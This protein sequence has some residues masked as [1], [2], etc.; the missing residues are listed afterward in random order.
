[1]NDYHEK[2]ARKLLEK[3]DLISYGEAL[4]WVELLWED[5]ESTYAKAGH[6]YAGEEMTMR[7]VNTWIDN[8]GERLHE[9]V[10]QNPKYKD[11]F[12]N[13]QRYH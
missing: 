8:Y 5:F 12:A 11:F 1:M 13:Q 7:V 10:A 9:F 2:L 4:T 3:N 6:E